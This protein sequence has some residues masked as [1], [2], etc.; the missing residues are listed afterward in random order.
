MI[1]KKTDPDS[2]APLAPAVGPKTA[3]PTM[4]R[5]VKSTELLGGGNELLIEHNGGV[6][7]LRQTSSGKLILTK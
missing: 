1:D 3:R 6:Y 7:S 2:L 5:T 4:R